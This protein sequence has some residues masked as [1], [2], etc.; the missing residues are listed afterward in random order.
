MG[1]VY[2][3]HD[4]RLNR[5][6]ALKL[7][8]ADF[9]RDEARAR[10]FIQEARAVSA[11]NHPNIIT[12]HEIGQSQGQRYIATEFFEGRTLRQIIAQGKPSLSESLEVTVQIASAL[13]A[14]HDAGIVH[15]P[16]AIATLRRIGS[17]VEAN[18]IRLVAVLN[19]GKPYCPVTA[20]AHLFPFERHKF[21]GWYVV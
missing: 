16:I 20:R 15:R 18:L 14:A 1:E 13:Q 17:Q 5:Q 4:P 3:A 12:I 19:V 9:A 8:P 10:R 7:L 6:V 11:L 21:T 2:L